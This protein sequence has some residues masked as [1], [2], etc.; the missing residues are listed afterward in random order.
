MNNKHVIWNLKLQ[1]TKIE[2]LPIVKTATDRHSCHNLEFF[3][4]GEIESC[5]NCQYEMYIKRA[6]HIYILHSERCACH[7]I[8]WWKEVI[9]QHTC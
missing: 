2:Y 9:N 6:F 1:K 3:T 4:L 5:N 8:N 7:S